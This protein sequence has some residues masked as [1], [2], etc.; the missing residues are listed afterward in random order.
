MFGLCIYFIRIN[1]D[2]VWKYVVV[3]D[4]IP[5]IR[6]PNGDVPAFLYVEPNV[7]GEI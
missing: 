4:Y 2:G 5:I 7:D 1:H 6:T 3:D